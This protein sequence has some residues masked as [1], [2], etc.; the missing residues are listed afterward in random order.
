MKG[1]PSVGHDLRIVPFVTAVPER[2][3]TGRVPTAIFIV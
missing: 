3:S 2:L 1:S